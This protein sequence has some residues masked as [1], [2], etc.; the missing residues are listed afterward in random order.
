[1]NVTTTKCNTRHARLW[2]AIGLLFA[3]VLGLSPT[4]YSLY[5]V[6]YDAKADA[7]DAAS[8]TAK[9]KV[10]VD[11][12]DKAYEAQNQHVRDSLERIERV[13]QTTQSDVRTTQEDVKAILRNGKEK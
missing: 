11:A 9:L 6:T 4:I 10:E 8:D 1:M 12:H 2:W 7:K 5:G 13:Q 3:A